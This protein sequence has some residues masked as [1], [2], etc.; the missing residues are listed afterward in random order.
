MS[1]AWGPPRAILEFDEWVWRDTYVVTGNSDSS[2]RKWELPLPL[3]GSG[4]LGAG[5]VMIKGR[6][7]VEKVQKAGRGGRRGTGNQKGTIVWGV[8]VLS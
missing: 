8:G 2:F 5:R 3:D 4:N 1:T 6:S 7:V